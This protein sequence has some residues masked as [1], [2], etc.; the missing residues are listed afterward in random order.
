MFCMLE[1]CTNFCL[2]CVLSVAINF[3]FEALKYSFYGIIPFMLIFTI[4][5]GCDNHR[6]SQALRKKQRTCKNS[7]AGICFTSSVC[8]LWCCGFIVFLVVGPGCGFVWQISC[9]LLLSANWLF[10]TCIYINTKLRLLSIYWEF[11]FSQ[12]DKVLHN[13]NLKCWYYFF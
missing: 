12:K 10:M 6:T 2:H 9:V 11:I 1:C 3:S 7:S 5:L 13:K 8:Q 4:M